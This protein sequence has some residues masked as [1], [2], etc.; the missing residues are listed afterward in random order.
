MALVAGRTQYS[1][2]QKPTTVRCVRVQPFS[3]TPAPAR[4]HR[5]VVRA[6]NG[7]FLHGTASHI[8]VRTVDIYL[9]R[10]DCTSCRNC[11][12]CVLQFGVVIRD[13]LLY[14]GDHHGPSNRHDTVL[15]C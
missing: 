11:T 13:K 10:F 1:A 5:Y 7:M 8:A 3:A 4:G 12:L 15:S 14:S 2:L 9:H 6:A